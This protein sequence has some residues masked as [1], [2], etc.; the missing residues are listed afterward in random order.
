VDID[1]LVLCAGFGMS[2]P[3]IAHDPDRI[4]QM[5]P[6]NIEATIALAST[7]APAMAARDTGSILIV[8]SFAGNQPIPNFG[9]HAATKAAITSFQRHSTPNSSQTA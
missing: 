5:V 4:Q 7:Y 3:F 8:S 9:V 6:S 2:G 1:V